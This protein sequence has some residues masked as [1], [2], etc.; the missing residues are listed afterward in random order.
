MQEDDDAI[1]NK[2]PEKKHS[3]PQTSVT[4]IVRTLSKDE[5]EAQRALNEFCKLYWSPLYA[6]VRRTGR[7][8]EDASDMV[9]AFATRYFVQENLLSD[10]QP[11]KGKLRT[12]L[13]A[14]LKNFLKNEF[15]RDTAAKRGGRQMLL[16]I[17][18]I[19]EEQR[20]RNIPSDELSADEVFDYQWGLTLVDEAM[21]HLREKYIRRGKMREFTALQEALSS[22]SSGE[23]G[24]SFEEIGDQ[25]KATAGN[26]RT[27]MHRFKKLFREQLE[28]VVSETVGAGK[29]D[30]EIAILRKMG[31]VGLGEV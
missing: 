6:Y 1:S 19:V 8:P 31:A 30:E 24:P 7:S 25:L 29:V 15:R 26:A 27:K 3:F 21:K 10:W 4:L 13:M 28:L 9:Q 2:S 5:N 12:Y 23:K 22:R 16:S 17:D 11:E 14:V 18:D 20:Y